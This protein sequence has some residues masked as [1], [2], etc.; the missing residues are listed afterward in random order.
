MAACCVFFGI[1]QYANRSVL[2]KGDTVII[3]CT[4]EPI[5]DKIGEI[6]RDKILGVGRADLYG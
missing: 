4:I 1:E 5:S 3:E 2:N 6:N